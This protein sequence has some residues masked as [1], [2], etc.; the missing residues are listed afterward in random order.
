[1]ALA[2]LGQPLIIR[3]GDAVEVL[4]ELIAAFDIRAIYVHQE[5]W[6]SWTYDRDRRVIAWARRA[7]ITIHEFR[8]HGVHRAM[9][10][11]RLGVEMGCNDAPARHPGAR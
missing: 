5:T 10:S 4:S 9:A 2:R 1:M 3:T 6:N 8:Q 7:Q 11:R